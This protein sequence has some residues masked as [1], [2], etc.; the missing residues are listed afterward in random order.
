MIFRAIFGF[1]VALTLLQGLGFGVPPAL[2]AVKADIA[3]SRPEARLHTLA[4]QTSSALVTRIGTAR[5]E[6]LRPSR[7][8]VLQP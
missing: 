7:A 8:R 4:G 1:A 6:I 5:R 3:A 2:L